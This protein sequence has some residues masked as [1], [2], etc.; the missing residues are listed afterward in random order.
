[1]VGEGEDANNLVAFAKAIADA[2]VRFFGAAWCPFCNEQKAL[3]EDG[4][5]YLPFIE[6]TNPDRTANQIGIDE[7]IDQ[8]PRGTLAMV[9]VSRA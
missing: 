6:V 4:A 5:K 8:Y 9:I 3:F 1:M 2:G 7:G